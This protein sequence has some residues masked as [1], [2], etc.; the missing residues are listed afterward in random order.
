MA[1]VYI[2]LRIGPGREQAYENQGIADGHKS[3]QA[4]HVLDGLLHSIINLV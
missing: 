2:D 1:V 3:V 4:T